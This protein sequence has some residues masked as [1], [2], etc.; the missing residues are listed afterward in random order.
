MAPLKASYTKRITL[1]SGYV[2]AVSL[3]C[4]PSSGVYVGNSP[5]DPGANNLTVQGTLT[6][7]GGVLP[8]TDNASDIGSSSLRW[9]TIYAANGTIQ[10]SHSRGKEHLH[11]LSPAAAM[12]A[13]REARIVLHKYRGQDRWHVGVLAEQVSRLLSPDHET[14]SPQT[15]AS[16]ALAAIQQL[17][18]RLARIEQALG[19]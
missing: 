7:G 2:G 16:V 17:D 13:V 18:A 1:T 8:S 11:T 12:Q 9:R 3:S 5:V 4:I 14:V 10:T 15:T 19:I 6:V